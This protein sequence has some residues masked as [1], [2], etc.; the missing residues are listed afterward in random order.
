MRQMLI[1]V[2]YSMPHHSERKKDMGEKK[3]WGNGH[4]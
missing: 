3:I 4:M 1:E 2:C